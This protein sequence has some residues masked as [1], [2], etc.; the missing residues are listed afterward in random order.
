MKKSHR[1]KDGLSLNNKKAH[2]SDHLNWSRR[3]FLQSVGLT[4]SMSLLLGKLP[5][6][7]FT[8]SA[9]DYLGETE[10]ILVLIRLA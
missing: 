9:M 7:A 1:T 4:T 8:S 2:E 6:K 5:L 3:G 10:R